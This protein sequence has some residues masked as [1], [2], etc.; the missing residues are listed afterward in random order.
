M[1][2]KCNYI[3]SGRVHES[4]DLARARLKN[5]K[6][7]EVT[8][9]PYIHTALF[10]SQIPISFLKGF[11]KLPFKR[12]VL[13][14]RKKNFINIFNFEKIISYL[15]FLSTTTFFSFLSAKI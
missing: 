7:T 13:N 15:I 4:V 10:P 11:E 5:Q 6:C 9:P 12:T 1:K 2:S 8:L 14:K 3:K